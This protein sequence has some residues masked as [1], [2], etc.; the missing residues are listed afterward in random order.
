M[1]EEHVKGLMARYK[2]KEADLSEPKFCDQDVVARALAGGEEGVERV[3]RVISTN[4]AMHRFGL[5]PLVSSPVEAKPSAA[6]RSASREVRLELD[7]EEEAGMKEAGLTPEEYA[8]V[9]GDGGRICGMRINIYLYHRLL[10]KRSAKKA[11][12][13]DAQASRQFLL[14]KIKALARRRAEKRLVF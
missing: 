10:H 1:L 8:C 7:E 6:F 13:L 3:M 11:R 2:V 5:S 4:K 12:S 9:R 14:Q